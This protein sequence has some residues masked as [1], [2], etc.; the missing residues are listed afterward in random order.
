MWPSQPRQTGLPSQPK[1]HSARPTVR[2]PAQQATAG[3]HRTQAHTRSPRDGRPSK[4]Q[5]PQ[6][7]S[8]SRDAKGL[9]VLFSLAH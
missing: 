3:P 9:R 7:V 6:P 1:P 4:P 8:P 5:P 2:G